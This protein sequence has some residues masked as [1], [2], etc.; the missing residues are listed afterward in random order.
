MKSDTPKVLH[1]IAG[2]SMLGHAITALVG[3]GATD[4]VVVVGPDRADV[5][6]EALATFGK[7]RIVVQHERLGTAHAVLAAREA[8]MEGHDDVVVAFADTPLMTTATFAGMRAAIASG[9]HVLAVGFEAADPTGYGR[10]VLDSEGLGAIVEHKD[11]SVA[12]RNIGLCNAGLLALSGRHALDIISRV[13]NDNAQREYYLTDAVKI[14]RGLGLSAQVLIAPEDEVQGVNDRVQ[15]ARAEA[16]MQ[17]RLRDA[18]MRAGA[19]LLAPETV[20]F[21]HDTK[22]GRDVIVEPNVFFGTGVVVEDQA[23]IHACSHLEGAH[24]GR[25]ASVGPFARLRP[26]ADLGEKAKVGNF[27][28]IKAA[29]LGVGAKVSHLS[30]IG[31]A[32]VGAGANIGAGTITCNYDGFSK[33]RTVI[34]EGAFVGSNSSLVAPVT[35]A[36]GAYVGS[37]TVVTKDVSADALAVGRAR[38]VEIAGWASQFRARKASSRKA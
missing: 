7:A 35:I 29:S 9:T 21:S 18:A 31:D 37:G 5:A 34:G 24:V 3:A 32:S 28:E 38:Q 15:L 13:G 1:A 4:V 10:M 20:Y 14:A 26:G 36:A 6:K 12:E 25:K 27:V 17:K 16:T 33:F 22:I 8:L 23:V 30:Y 11:A 19:T 2:R